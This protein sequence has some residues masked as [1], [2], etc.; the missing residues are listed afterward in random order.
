LESEG[1]L[2]GIFPDDVYQQSAVELQPGDRVFI[3]S[4]GVEMAFSPADSPGPANWRELL[5]TRRDLPTEQIIA[6]LRELLV[7]ADA[8]SD[9][10]K[11]DLTVIAVEVER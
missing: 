1:A 11:D 7:G 3:Y 2:L 4:D 10:K 8:N 9:R 6:E 5:Y